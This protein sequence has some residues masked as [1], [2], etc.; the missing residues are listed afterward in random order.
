MKTIFS[1]SWQIIFV[2]LIIVMASGCSDSGKK[3]STAPGANNIQSQAPGQAAPG[4]AAVA[5]SGDMAASVDGKVLKKA[6]LEQSV[7][8]R[9]NFY[10]GKVPAD[11]QQELKD[12]I[13][14]QLVEL[15]VTRTILS[16]E[17]EKRK[18]T[19]SSEEVKKAIDNIKASLPPEKKIDDFFKENRITQ[20]DIILAVKV[21]KFRRMEIS[22]SI[23]PSEKEITAFYNENR[24]KL[25]NQPESVHVRHILV[26]VG[27]DD[28]DKVKAEK[29]EKIENVRKQLVGG[30]NF[31][32][33][34]RKYSDCPSKEAGGD[35]SFIK[36]GQMVKDFETAAFS[37]EKN[38]IGPVVK[39]EYGYHI[40]QV[41][42]KK[43]AK[44]VALSEVKGKI[45]QFLEQ[46][47]TTEAFNEV[48]KKLRANAKV[49]IYQ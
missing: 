15:F 38:A 18:I 12:T 41:L 23:K 33:L 42:D 29:K 25:F 37:Q 20:D 26:A 47:K 19:A 24:D 6:E 28:T 14:K 48:L 44:K 4:N 35:L 9:F 36:K 31:A 5:K 13:R 40:I 32:E 2:L 8:D 45:T 21:D 3:E 10:K 49:E 39:T 46:K 17:I 16:N 11:K 30:G 7:N 22:K 34:A 27:K 43:P 1:K